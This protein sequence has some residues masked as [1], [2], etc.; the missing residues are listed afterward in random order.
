MENN[1]GFS[2]KSLFRKLKELRK[3][4]IVCVENEIYVYTSFYKLCNPISC[5][6]L[7]NSTTI[8]LISENEKKVNSELVKILCLYYETVQKY[9]DDKYKIYSTPRPRRVNSDEDKK[10]LNEF[11]VYSEENK[12][13]IS[14]LRVLEK[15][16]TNK[17]KEIETL[18]NKLNT[19]I[20]RYE[21]LKEKLEI[22]ENKKRQDNV[23]QLK[24]KREII[25]L[26]LKIIELEKKISTHKKECNSYIK[27]LNNNIKKIEN[28]IEELTEKYKSI[29]LGY[30]KINEE[31]IKMMV[32]IEEEQ[33]RQEY[34]LDKDLSIK[35]NK[36]KEEFIKYEFIPITSDTV[37]EGIN[38]I[39]KNKSYGILKYNDIDGSLKKD[40]DYL[41]S[42]YPNI[43][44]YE[45]FKLINCSNNKGYCTFEDAVRSAE[46]SRNSYRKNEICIMKANKIPNVLSD[47]ILR[48]KLTKLDTYSIFK[49]YCPEM[50]YKNKA[51]TT[52]LLQKDVRNPKG[53]SLIYMGS[54]QDVK[55]YYSTHLNKRITEEREFFTVS[56]QNVFSLYKTNEYNYIYFMGTL[57]T[58]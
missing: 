40:F 56:R 42:L 50:E 33:E 29:I 12:C 19:F 8:R 6:S 7:S 30:E 36:L 28:D 24:L 48:Q 20:S 16:K 52:L 55:E 10:I 18:K 9:E 23:K 13:L 3:G 51:V 2:Y 27:N 46:N 1:L 45:I 11:K 25:N 35:I 37:K 34:N 39:L 4:D 15:E 5:L 41:Q 21:D 57:G 54:S 49:Y 22:E 38:K 47:E 58:L 32:D 31:K 43:N 14:K 26:E 17:L 53:Y 44:V